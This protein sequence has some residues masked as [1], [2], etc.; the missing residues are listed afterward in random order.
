MT[1]F[2]PC[3]D[4]ATVTRLYPEDKRVT[5]YIPVKDFDDA[6]TVGEEVAVVSAVDRP[7]KPLPRAERVTGRVK[8]LVAEVELDLA[9]LDAPH[10]EGQGTLE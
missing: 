6:I 5:V 4:L 10:H 8:R 2:A 9:T 3:R 7:G 1:A